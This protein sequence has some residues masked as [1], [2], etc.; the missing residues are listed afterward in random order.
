MSLSSPSRAL[1]HLLRGIQHRIGTYIVS[2]VLIVSVP[3]LKEMVEIVRLGTEYGGWWVPAEEASLRFSNCFSVG[4]GEDISFDVELANRFGST[5]IIVDPTPRALLHFN[6]VKT[7]LYGK[8]NHRDQP[9]HEPYDAGLIPKFLGQLRFVSVGV[10]DSDTVQKFFAPKISSHV[11]HSIT[12]LQATNEYFEAQCYSIKTL[13]ELFSGDVAPSLLKLDIEG[14]EHR[15]IRQMLYDGVRPHLL[16]IEFDDGALR[17][18]SRT[19]RLL[20]RSGYRRAKV[21]NR[22]ALFILR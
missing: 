13:F 1:I 16:L 19:G 4:A 14:A 10:W 2:F 5:V 20:R 9:S 3:P 11:S 22:N 12:N 6:S 21:E 17:A 7:Q 18:M 8:S 15:V